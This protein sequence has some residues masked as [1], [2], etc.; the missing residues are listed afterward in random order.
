MNIGIIGIGSFLPDNRVTNVDLEKRMDTSDEWIRT[1]TG[2]EARHLADADMSVADM[3]TRAAKR[4]LASAGVV[5]EDIDA[6]V[7]ATATAPSF[8]ATACLVQANLGAKRA[9]AFDVSAACSGFIFAMD[10]AKS[11]MQSKGFKRT[12]VIGAEK[13]GNLIDWDDRSTAVLFGDGAGA[14]VLGED[15]VAAIDSIVLGSDGTGGKFLYE[16][17]DGKIVMNG[18]EVFKFAVRKMPDIVLEALHQAGKDIADMDVL[19]P[20]QANRRIIDAAIERLGL[21][22]DK[23]VVTI[24]DHA[25]TSAASIPLALAEAVKIGKVTAGQTVVIAGFGAGLTWGA[26]CLTWNNAKITEEICS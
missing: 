15:D 6:I 20:H 23:V 7:C 3:A 22:E 8:P 11:L 16:N 12:L 1:R 17:A 2:I 9:V 19:V 26:S 21:A 25:N 5:I 13:M 14:V 18:R 10:T 24:Q 4:A